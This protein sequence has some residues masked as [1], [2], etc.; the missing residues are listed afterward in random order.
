M[1]A[2]ALGPL[3][4]AADPFAVVLGIVGF[5][6]TS[7][8]LARRVDHRFESWSWWTLFIGADGKLTHP[9]LG[10]ISSEALQDNFLRLNRKD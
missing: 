9:H 1:N 8:S 6:V 3:V 10:E 4:P 7:A 5:L 2:I